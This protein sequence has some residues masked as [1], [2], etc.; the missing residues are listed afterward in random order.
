MNLGQTIRFYRKE[1]GLTLDQLAQISKLSAP[2][3]SKLENGK[4][5]PSME[6]LRRLAEAFDVPL[7]ALTLTEERTLLNPV[8]AGEGFLMRWRGKGDSSVQVRYLT[9]GRNAKMQPIIVAIPK[10][11][12]TGK[13]RSHPG[14]EFFYVLHG[15]IRFFYGEEEVFEMNEG[16]FLYY[17]SHIPHHWEN[18]GAEDAQVLTCNTPPVI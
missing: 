14:D 6:S 15:R 16:D 18:I 4:S 10:G 5:N 1:K 9:Q 2:Q 7:S 3:L 12:D 13:S 11:V 8:R 17:E